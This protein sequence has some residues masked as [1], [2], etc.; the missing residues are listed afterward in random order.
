M[1]E[2]ESGIDKDSTATRLQTKSVRPTNSISECDFAKMDRLLREKPNAS[3]L[4]I[5]AHILFNNKTAKWLSGKSAKEKEI[6]FSSARKLAPVHQKRFRARLDSLC[7]QIELEVAEKQRQKQQKEAKA[8]AEKEKLTAAIV[9]A[10]LWQSTEQVERVAYTTQRTAEE[11]CSENPPQVQEDSSTTNSFQPIS[12]PVFPE[13][14]WP[15]QLQH[16]KTEPS[17]SS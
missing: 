7:Q 2:S 15:I 16:S 14:H 11:G 4:A 6:L 3:M 13:G 10:E 12:L 8:L 9:V 1:Q 17:Q 5:E